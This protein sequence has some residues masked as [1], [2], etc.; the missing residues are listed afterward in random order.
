[1]SKSNKN[2]NPKII[3][4]NNEKE[5]LLGVHSTIGSQLRL[6]NMDLLDRKWKKVKSRML[7]SSYGL[8]NYFHRFFNVFCKFSVFQVFVKILI[9]FSVPPPSR[10]LCRCRRGRR[11]GDFMH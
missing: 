1:M 2:F 11:R 8:Y 3:D 7:E 9:F 10:N 6:E 4:K 5:F